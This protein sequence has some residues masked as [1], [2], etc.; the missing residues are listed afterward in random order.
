[1]P[2]SKGE[3][4]GAVVRLNH[5]LLVPCDSQLATRNSRLATRDLDSRK[6]VFQGQG[7]QLKVEIVD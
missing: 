6:G 4:V 2:S 3:V 7:L 1:M 5:R